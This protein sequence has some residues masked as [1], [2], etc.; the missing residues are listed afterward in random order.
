MSASTALHQL[1]EVGRRVLPNSIKDRI[2]PI[3][4]RALVA[5]AVA[6][7]GTTTTI[8]RGGDSWEIEYLP[9]ANK[10]YAG[11]VADGAIQPEGIPIEYLNAPPE[12]DAIIDAGAH[13][14]VYS[15]LCALLN[16]ET[17]VFAYEPDSYSAGIAQAT[18][19]LNNLEATVSANLVMGHTGTATLHRAPET[20][21][22][23]HSTAAARS[24]S[25]D[26]IEVDCVALSDVFSEKNIKRPWVKIDVE[27]AETAVLRDLRDAPQEVQ[28]LVEIHPDK[29]SDSQEV[30]R[31][32]HD[33]AT[34]EFVGDTSP[35][36]PDNKTI[37]G[38]NRPMYAFERL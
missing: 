32:L 36:H 16:S 11:L 6:T 12:T 38:D 25:F 15:V 27:G 26:Q 8:T 28:G 4:N 18:L 30:I 13:V 3:Y 7:D 24:D 35:N 1:A 21:S 33:T 2:R 14:G 9:T 29:L 23:S 17:P 20:G 5:S 19:A 31:K 10:Y 37:E 34:V 22:V